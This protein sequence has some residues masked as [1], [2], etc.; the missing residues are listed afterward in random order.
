MQ[1]N[2]V[3]EFKTV[4]EN[5][6]FTLSIGSDARKQMLF[7]IYECA[8]QHYVCSGLLRLDARIHTEC[9][10]TIAMNSMELEVILDSIYK[11]C[12]LYKISKVEMRINAR[13]LDRWIA[14][15]KETSLIRTH[16]DEGFGIRHDDGW[17][18]EV[19]DRREINLTANA[20]NSGHRVTHIYIPSTENKEIPIY[21]C[22]PF[23]VKKVNPKQTPAEPESKSTTLNLKVETSEVTATI[24]SFG[25]A[26]T[27]LAGEIQVSNLKAAVRNPE[28]REALF[29]AL[30][31]DGDREALTS[32]FL[33]SREALFDIEWHEANGR[34]NHHA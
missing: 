6:G 9:Y 32:L 29:E 27:D 13:E 26:V 3:K 15:P 34:K 7:A 24:G 1:F 19:A 21:P 33:L 20:A 30:C 17:Q 12:N 23:G 2:K 11:F 5:T 10:P 25:K 18:Q 14:V 4:Y 31:K 16:N 22:E 28:V 8:H